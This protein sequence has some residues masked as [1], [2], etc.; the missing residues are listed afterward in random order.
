MILDLANLRALVTGGTRGIGRAVTEVLAAGGV[1]VAVNY[2]GKTPPAE[3]LERL[4]GS[5][6]Y[7]HLMLRA[8]VTQ[9]R[10]VATMMRRI[11]EAWGG[12]D[13]LVLNHGIRQKQPITAMSHGDWRE[14]IGTNLTGTFNVLSEALPLLQKDDGG[15]RDKRII[16]MASTAGLRGESRHAH[17]AAT[18]GGIVALTKSLAAELGPD[19]ITVNA[20]APGWIDTDMTADELADV[21]TRERVRSTIPLGRFGQPSD[22]ASAVAFLASRQAEWISGEVLVVNGGS[23][24]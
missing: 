16:F 20:V 17:Y 21:E 24:I 12:L 7:E 13:L 2:K 19:R 9:E 4:L 10:A 15:S 18:K 14:N 8:D 5:R 3:D 22:V 1:R 11:E 23:T 6:G